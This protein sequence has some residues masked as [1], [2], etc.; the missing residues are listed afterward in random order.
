VNLRGF[1]L[2]RFARIAPLLLLLL[3]VLSGLHFANVHNFVVTSKTGG[4][5]RALLAALTFHVN[6][7]EAR[8]GY[9]PGNWDILWSLSVEEMFYLFF[10]LVCRL[11]GRRRLF[12]AILLVFV[13]LGAPGRTVFAHG[14]EVWSEYCYLGGTEGI[15]LGCLT[16]IIVSRIQFSRGALRLLGIGGTT[17][18]ALSLVLSLQGYKG[19][20]GRTGLNFTVIGLGTCMFITATSQAQWRSPRILMPLLKIGQYSYEV[21]LTHMFVVFGLFGLF[22]DLGKPMALV[23]VLFTTTILVAGFL[24]AAVAYCYSEPMN[25]K[26]RQRLRNIQHRPAS[27]VDTDTIVPNEGSAV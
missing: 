27:V 8:R 26:L 13:V 21:Y 24:G 18:V 23:P 15:A 1:Y 25:R 5:G 9:L 4:L 14:N 2:F 12:L 22:L 17:I 20:L 3:A 7:L 10:P 19:W 6:V 11:F 16:A